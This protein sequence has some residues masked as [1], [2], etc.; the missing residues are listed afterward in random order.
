MGRVSASSG[1]AD[2]QAS[3]S[4]AS[5]DDAPHHEDDERPADREEPRADL[6]EGAEPLSAE[7]QAA[8]PAAEQ[9]AGHA[10]DQGADPAPALAPGEDELGDRA[11]DQPEK[12]EREEAH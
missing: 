7:Q 12:Q 5:R 8:E 10:D 11:R 4:A 9:G 3:G 6:E 1:T 2:T